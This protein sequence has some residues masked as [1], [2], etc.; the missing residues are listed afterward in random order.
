MV[1]KCYNSIQVDGSR[2]QGIDK[3]LYIHN[4][5]GWTLS[6]ADTKLMTID[7]LEVLSPSKDKEFN[8]QA[9]VIRR[10]FNTNPMR[11]HEVREDDVSWPNTRDEEEFMSTRSVSS[12]TPFYTAPNSSGEKQLAM[13]RLGLDM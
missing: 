4:S 9:D 5:L 13:N 2:I 7:G 10:S 11:M 8:M 3:C 1:E 6:Q 12:E